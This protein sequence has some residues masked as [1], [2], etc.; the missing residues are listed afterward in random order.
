VLPRWNRVTKHIFQKNIIIII[1]I[2]II[3]FRAYY[4]DTKF[5]LNLISALSK[6]HIVHLQ[7]I[8]HKHCGCMF[9]IYSETLLTRKTVFFFFAHYDLEDHTAAT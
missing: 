8:F 9:M 5:T 7:T 3:L 1:I 6:F 4:L 2:I